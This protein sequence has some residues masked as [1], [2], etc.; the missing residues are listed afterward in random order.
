MTTDSLVLKLTI[1]GHMSPYNYPHILIQTALR[2]QN[3]LTVLSVVSK[4]SSCQ[5]NLQQFLDYDSLHFVEYW[6]CIITYAVS[7]PM[8]ALFGCHFYILGFSLH[9]ILP[10]VFNLIENFQHTDTFNVLPFLMHHQSQIVQKICFM[11]QVT[12]MVYPIS[13][14]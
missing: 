1:H 6:Y 11:K 5:T 7:S 4:L 2:R 9:F 12:F 13:P 10:E 8:P 14:K 3:C